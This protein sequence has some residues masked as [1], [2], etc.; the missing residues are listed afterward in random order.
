[1]IDDIYSP[2]DSEEVTQD[3]S[4]AGAKKKIASKLQ[5]ERTLQSYLRSDQDSLKLERIRMNE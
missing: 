2:N 4:K 1:M 3:Y 5:R